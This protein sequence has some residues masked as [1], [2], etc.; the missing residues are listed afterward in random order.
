MYTKTI[1]NNGYRQAQIYQ[2]KNIF[3]GYLYFSVDDWI[4]AYKKIN[5]DDN[6]CFNSGAG[7]NMGMLAIESMYNLYDGKTVN[8][9]IID[10]SKTRNLD[11]SLMK[12]FNVNETKFYNNVAEYAKNSIGHG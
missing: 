3:P 6:F 8:D 12:Y 2:I 4:N 9:F 11:Q 5:S 10:Y 7:Y 1:K